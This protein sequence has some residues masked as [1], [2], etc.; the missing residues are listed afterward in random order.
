MKYTDVE[1]DF[2]GL[3]DIDGVEVIS[4]G[5]GSDWYQKRDYYVLYTIGKLFF[6]GFIKYMLEGVK[7]EPVKVISAFQNCKYLK[8]T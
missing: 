3:D 7:L 1:K 8:S 5:F 6:W 2:V 4:M